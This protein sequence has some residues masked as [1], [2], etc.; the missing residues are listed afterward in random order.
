M[1]NLRVGH[2]RVQVLGDGLCRPYDI[3]THVRVGSDSFPLRL[4]SRACGNPYR[5]RCQRAF[6]VIEVYYCLQLL[7]AQ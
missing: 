7:R 2:A 1:T 6:T 4:G 5:P 3:L